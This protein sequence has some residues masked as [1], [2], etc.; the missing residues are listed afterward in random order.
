MHA[1]SA[2]R[3]AASS[4]AP[5]ELVLDLLGLHLLGREGR[6]R[7]QA[8]GGAGELV[9][10]RVFLATLSQLGVS[11]SATRSTLNRLVLRGQLVR[12]RDGRTSAFRPDE[13]TLALLRRGR[14]RMFSTTPFD[15]G[16][17]VWTI[18]SCPIP[19]DLR[20][21][22]YLVHTRLSW[23]GFGLV[24]SNLWV[25]PGR[26]DVGELLRDG[27]PAQSLS[28]VHAFHGAPVP[29]SSPQHLI[30]S[31]WDRDALRAAHLAFTDRW[32]DADRSPT[33]ALPQFLLLL[34]DWGRLL[35]TDPG[36]PAADHDPDWPAPAS[37]DLFRQLNGALG[38]LAEEHLRDLVRGAGR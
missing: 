8:A 33:D 37:A 11:G 23:A 32:M 29:P 35:R 1:I 26:I 13:G 38:A 20:N 31:A 6:G 7:D 19:E 21:L 34:Q 27:L 18:L 4:P 36:L 9:P 12:H 25:A 17:R 22:R 14:D 15:P 30:G 16:A 10:T 3:A 28:L 5:P 24:R 2:V